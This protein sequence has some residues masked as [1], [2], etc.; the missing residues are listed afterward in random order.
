[1]G[2]RHVVN[3]TLDLSDRRAVQ[4]LEAALGRASQNLARAI[5]RRAASDAPRDT[6][7]LA[8]SFRVLPARGR[9][10]FASIAT[11][12]EHFP[13]VEGGSRGKAPKPEDIERWVVRNKIK[14]RRRRGRRPLKGK[15]AARAVAFLI[16]RAQ[17]RTRGLRFYEKAQRETVERKARPL[18]QRE[19]RSLRRER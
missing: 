8:G 17:R 11:T 6:G 16:A 19:L 13:P 5:A 9:R 15:A 7:E 12:S 14:P 10:T 3:A 4:R 18:F 1:M 2:R